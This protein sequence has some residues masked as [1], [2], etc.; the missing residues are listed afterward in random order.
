MKKGIIAMIA[1]G[2][3]GVLLFGV[4]IVG[5]LLV[6]R[7]NSLVTANEQIDGAWAQVENVL[8]RRG[9]LIPN[10][11]ATVQGFADQEQEI[12]TDVANARSR[13]AG[14]VTPAEAGAAN[15]GLT[16]ALG[17]LLAISENYPQLRSNE[18]FIRLQDELAGSENRIAVERRRY[19]DAVRA[20][21]TQVLRFPTNMVAGMFGF[22]DR[23]YFEADE[24]AAEVPQVAF[25]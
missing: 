8:Q 23:E 5:G 15:A 11:V 25:Q 14:A 10:L 19:N 18:N 16:G 3:L 21:N 17:R 24:A 12:F 1:I 13:L 20:Y 2:V 22:S 9:D 4:L 6:S 7:Y